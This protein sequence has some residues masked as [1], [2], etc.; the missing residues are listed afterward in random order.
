MKTI[1]IKKLQMGRCK[2]SI[3]SQIGTIKDW[4]ADFCKP[5]FSCKGGCLKSSNIQNLLI[6]GPKFL[7]H[8]QKINTVVDNDKWH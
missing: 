4:Y 3:L 2:I 6:A 5:K 8:W 7:K 1:L